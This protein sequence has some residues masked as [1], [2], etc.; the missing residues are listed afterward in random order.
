MAARPIGGEDPGAAYG[1]LPLVS[2]RNE[3]RESRTAC[4]SA[5]A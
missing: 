2:P 3:L 5:E 1:C 4:S